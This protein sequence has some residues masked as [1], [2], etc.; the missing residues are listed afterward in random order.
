HCTQPLMKRLGIHA[1][2]RASVYAYNTREDI[3]R[4]IEGLAEVRSVFGLS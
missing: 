4:L 2:A 1:T 3:D